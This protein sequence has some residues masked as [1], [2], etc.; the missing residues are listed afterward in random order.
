MEEIN[1][2]E[3]NLDLL[4]SIYN[5]NDRIIQSSPY[6][7]CSTILINL[8]HGFL[9]PDK[10]YHFVEDNI[11]NKDYIKNFLVVKTHYVDVD[12]LINIQ[13]EYNLYFV[14]SER[15]DN[16]YKSLID[17]V[18]RTYKNVL[19]INYNELNETSELP[20]KEIVENVF[21]LLRRQG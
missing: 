15:Y 7:T 13:K 1:N 21:V 19:I 14:M 5:T 9:C 16:K 10:P 8:V 2:Q 20:L 6:G 3:I 12:R 4:P 17:N 18:F 11:Y